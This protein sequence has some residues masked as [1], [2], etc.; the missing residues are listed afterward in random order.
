MKYETKVKLLFNSN[1]L[2]D[3][4][5]KIFLKESILSKIKKNKLPELETCSSNVSTKD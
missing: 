1:S 3:R 5:N 4:D 2:H